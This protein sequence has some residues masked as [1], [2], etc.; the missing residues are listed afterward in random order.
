MV[1]KGQNIVNYY[2]MLKFA[3]AKEKIQKYNIEDPVLI[4]FVYKFEKQIDWN[5]IS[6]PEDLNAYISKQLLPSVLSQLDTDSEDNVYIESVNEETIQAE[7]AQHQNNP[8]PQVQQAIQAFLDNPEIAQQHITQKL[9][10]MK[11]KGFM[12]WWNYLT[13]GNDIYA[14]SPAFVFMVMAP[15]LK[16]F[17]SQNQMSPPNINAA[18]LALTW[19]KLKDNPQLNVLKSY[20]K[21][22]TALKIEDR[23]GFSMRG[24]HWVKIPSEEN[25]PQNFEAN[26][27]ELQ[28]YGTYNVWCVA[29]KET[30]KHYL[31]QGDFYIYIRGGKARVAIRTEGNKM[32]E[33]EGKRNEMPSDYWEEILDFLH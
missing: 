27:K 16:A 5:Q 24:G 33:M 20:E 32:V 26:V 14:K 15:L 13:E 1:S 23:G 12:E 28:D 10:E 19:S 7:I 17:G 8:N 18:A 11:Q 31:S 4:A 3:G 30:A 2:I 25:D 22:D 29:E 9:N 21:E 6:E